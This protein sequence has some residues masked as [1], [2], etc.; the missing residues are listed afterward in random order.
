MVNEEII[1][2]S[3]LYSLL[4]SILIPN[5]FPNPNSSWILS[6]IFPPNPAYVVSYHHLL[7]PLNPPSNAGSSLLSSLDCATIGVFVL[8]SNGFDSI[9]CVRA[10]RFLNSSLNLQVKWFVKSE[11][12]VYAYIYSTMEGNG[13]AHYDGLKNMVRK[14]RSLTCRRPRPEGSI[15]L[16]PSDGFSKISSDDIPAFDTNPRRKEFSLSHCISRAESIAESERGNNDS[17]R[18]EIINRNKRSTEGVLAPASWKTPRLEDEGDGMS[19]GKGADLDERVGQTK[20]MKLKIGGVTRLVHANGSSGKSSK[21]VNDTTRSNNE[22]EESSE[23]CESPLDKKAD[24]QGVTW[25][26]EKGESM[27]G[28]GKQGE[29]TGSVRKS[30]RAPKKRAFDSD[31]DDND[32]EIRYLEKLKYKNVSV[33]NEDTES[34]RRQLKPSGITIG[35]ISGK[36]ISASENSPGDMDLAD[37]LE[38]VPDEKE[39]GNE[40]KRESTLTS[41]QRALASSAS[42]RSS[43]IEFPDGLPPTTSRRKKENLSEMEQQLKKAEAAQRR[44]VQIEKAARES[45]AEAIRKILGQDSS[46][47]KR[48][49]KIKKRLDEM[50]QEKAAHEEMAPTS[51]IR[52]IM[53]PSGTTVSFPIDKVPSL[54]DQQPVSYPPPRENCAGPSCTNPYKYRHSKTN[55]PLCSLKCYKAVDAQRQTTPAVDAQQQT[56]PAVDAQQQTAPAVDAQQQTA[57]A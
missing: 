24:L 56:A 47:K 54:F 15:L 16:T 51:F 42:G 9:V 1:S 40:I 21:P 2:L 10:W 14:K 30:K 12:S 45:E 28:R 5:S 13:G 7:Y 3:P 11:E 48:E 20:K 6:S 26:A 35:E 18:R 41:R 43:T 52:T 17:R 4:V 8:F 49:D 25:N 32:D 29:P 38:S 57:P 19:N 46:R 34:G 50:A 27:V 23:D 39:I 37:E 53:G 31:D 33:C 55:A 44:K 22:M 36:R